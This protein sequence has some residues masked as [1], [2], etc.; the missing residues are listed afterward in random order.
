MSHRE[1]M[2]KLG[3]TFFTPADEAKVRRDARYNTPAV[4]RDAKRRWQRATAL[5]SATMENGAGLA[6]DQAVRSFFAEFNSRLFNHGGRSLPLS[7]NVL[8][9]FV[10]YDAELIMFR[11][12]DEKDHLFSFSD[13][14]DF[15]TSS[16]A[17][18][19]P[20]ACVD[21]LEEAVIYNFTNLDDP[22]DLTF[23]TTTDEEYGIAGVSMIRQGD[24]LAVIV[25]AGRHADLEAES[26]S[27]GGIEVVFANQPEK[28]GLRT[29]PD[30]DRRAEPLLENRDL[31]KT[32]ALARFS[33]SAQTEDVRY[34]LVDHGDFYDVSTDDYDATS[35]AKEAPEEQRAR[36]AKQLREIEQ[37][38]VLFEVAKTAMLLPAYFAFK[39][40]LVRS[41]KTETALG[42]SGAKA[43]GNFRVREAIPPK[44]RITFRRV[45]ALRVIG[46]S[47]SAA[48]RFTAPRFRVPVDGFWRHIPG[49]VGRD[50]EGRP[51]DGRTWVKAHERWRELPERPIQVLVKS[52]VA[53]ARQIV[54]S[55]KL[56]HL[57]DE[58]GDATF[59]A[60]ASAPREV[61]REESYRQRRLLT[62][63]LKWK[64]LQR[65]DFRCRV[66]GRD[67]AAD[68]NVRLDVDHIMPVS[69]GGKTEPANL[70]TLCNQCN[71][72]K[73][74]LLP[75]M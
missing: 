47:S 10:A 28:D 26:A 34:V 73:G 30:L 22:H 70:R 1:R 45:S 36:E 31:W 39:L 67:A 49:R 19:D 61:S 6:M 12:R 48:R 23:S 16:D 40:T 33:L 5:A 14:I 66:C 4:Q 15:V 69:R 57:V 65:D 43:L 24:E 68:R 56:A 25:L 75:L 55:E 58:Q 63:R 18:S 53:V 21:D 42:T 11:L 50:A 41:E 2:E 71:N 74:D 60:N 20:F 52:R 51:V 35:D 13:F 44:S 37:R 59:E 29:H 9:A 62:A 54:E 38:R 72:G 32:I 27:I 46:G 8:E 64:I 17:P 7:F 3:I